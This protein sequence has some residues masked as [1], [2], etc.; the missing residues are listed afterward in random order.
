MNYKYI[1]EDPTQ[2]QIGK[3]DGHTIAMPFDS[4]EDAFEGESKY[5]LSLNGEW[6]FLWLND[7]E[8][9]SEEYKADD[10][11]DS[12][13]DDITVP[14][15]WQ[16]KGYGAPYYYASTY[17]RALSR[18]KS[19]IPSIDR[20]MQEIGWYRKTFTVPAAF[21]DKEVFFHIGACKAA[22]EVWINGDY[23]GYSCGSMTP[24]EFDVTSYLQKG[25]N[26]VCCKVYRFAASSY[27]ED[28]DM[29]WF[30]GIYREVFL[31]AEPKT[32][33]RDF[34]IK[35]DFDEE[36][37]DSDLSLDLFINN[38]SDKKKAVR[39]SAYLISDTEK[40]IPVGKASFEIGAKTKI[41]L[42][43]SE[44]I[45]SPKK[46]SAEQPNLYKLVMVLNDGKSECVKVW[47]LGFKKVEIVGE[48]ILFNGMPLMIRG[49]NR[50]DFDPDSGWA[51]PKERYA[52]DFD[53][54]KGCNINAIRCSHY[55]DDIYFYELAGQYG[56]YVM[57]ECDLETHGVRR[58]NVPGSNPLWTYLAVDKM[59]RMV[60]RDRNYPCTL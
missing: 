5:K 42:A 55:P 52:E 24:H 45:K 34:Y 22:V 26:L 57:D 11:D 30:S 1:W 59:E 31:Y 50:H 16:L 40:E 36:Y 13:W 23:V 18:K 14:S 51:V 4:A 56:F 49:T 28:Q 47:D 60:L 27:L 44:N 33:I 21:S 48:K 10:F 41:K 54:M 6:K 38:Y 8:K 46:W 9:D 39:A 43:L 25:E 12:V 32:C 29:W 19:K 53:L 37:K 3:E 15:V 17:P 2:E 20:S 7:I 58:K 35:T